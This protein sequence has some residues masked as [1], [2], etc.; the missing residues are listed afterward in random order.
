MSAPKWRRNSTSSKRSVCSLILM[1]MVPASSLRRSD[2]AGTIAISISE[3][4][5]RFDEVEFRR[6]LGALINEQK[7]SALAEIE[8]GTVILQVSRSAAETG[9]FV[10]SDL[11]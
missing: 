5:D 10:P 7:D 1:A 11:S 8:V 3:Q 9:L 2:E 6:H 4:T